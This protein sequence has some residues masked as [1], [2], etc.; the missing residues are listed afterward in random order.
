MPLT[1]LRVSKIALKYEDGT[2]NYFIPDGIEA[3][4]VIHGEKTAVCAKGAVRV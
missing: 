1:A 3:E 4:L 2:L